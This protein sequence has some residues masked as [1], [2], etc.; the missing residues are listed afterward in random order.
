[1]IIQ[2]NPL[3]LNSSWTTFYRSGGSTTQWKLW[4]KPANCSWIYIFMIGAGGGGGKG[5]GGAATVASGGGGSGGCARMIIP[6]AT[7]PS[8]LYINLAAG[9]N[10]ATTSC[11]GSAG[12]TSYIC[13]QPST[14]KAI[15]IFLTV[16]GGSGGA[17]AGAATA[18]TAASVPTSNWGLGLCVPS[19]I[20]GQNGGTGATVANGGGTFVTYGA[21]QGI[22]TSGGAGG[23]NGTGTG[24]GISR[25]GIGLPTIPGGAGTIGENGNFGSN[26]NSQV[27]I[28]D[29]NLL[30]ALCFSGGTGGGGHT[31]GQAGNGGD[32]SYG[33]GGGGAGNSS[34]AGGLAGNGGKG[35]DGFVIIGCF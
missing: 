23:S 31:T 1:M 2:P 15:D 24:G 14:S 3:D 11:N 12:G 32:A 9:G 26:F 28:V 16:P 20:A 17:G 8:K 29:N 25:D 19:F 34:T 5:A 6:A 30:Y 21:N 27:K 18:G 35:G 10:G 13:F 4:T 33:G 7:F 22:L